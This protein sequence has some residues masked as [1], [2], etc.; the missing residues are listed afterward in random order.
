MRCLSCDRKL[1]DYESTRKYASSGSFVDLCN[2]CFSEVS[3]D[4]PDI[5][6]DGFDHVYEEDEDETHSNGLE[7]FNGFGVGESDYES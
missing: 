6:G 7:G 4:I 3:E 2:R 1:S 5:E